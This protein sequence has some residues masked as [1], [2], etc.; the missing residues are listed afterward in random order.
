[1]SIQVKSSKHH[2]PIKVFESNFVFLQIIVFYLKNIYL[3]Y[4]LYLQRLLS[5]VEYAIS[6]LKNFFFIFEKFKRLNILMKYK[7]INGKYLK[8]Y[9]MDG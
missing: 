6:S 8:M 4:N 9:M 5:D 3:K 7:I 1:M 2:S